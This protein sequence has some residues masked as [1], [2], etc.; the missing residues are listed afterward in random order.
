MFGLDNSMWLL[1]LI[2]IVVAVLIYMNMGGDKVSAS[3]NLL[4]KKGAFEESNEDELIV[5]C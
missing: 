5:D 3:C 2:V 4:E 1:L